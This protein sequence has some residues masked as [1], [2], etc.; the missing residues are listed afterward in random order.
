MKKEMISQ[1][2]ITKGGWKV[3]SLTHFFKW[4]NFLKLILGRA[5][6]F[7]S[8]S[9]T[10]WRLWYFLLT[11][12]KYQTSAM[13]NNV[14]KADAPVQCKGIIMASQSVERQLL[15]W[16]AF[17]F[18]VVFS[19]GCLIKSWVKLLLNG[20]V[21]QTKKGDACLTA[22]ICSLCLFWSQSLWPVR[23]KHPF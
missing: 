11:S 3:L 12:T 18:N 2:H 13:R 5:E 4:P 17:F 19:Y 1:L 23:G 9:R 14:F 22:L 21:N 16:G 6:N 10:G 7:S 15:T 8:S 20:I